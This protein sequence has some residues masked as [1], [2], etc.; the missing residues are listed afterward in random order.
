MK[1]TEEV[2]LQHYIELYENSQLSNHIFRPEK[3][4]KCYSTDCTVYLLQYII[5]S[6]LVR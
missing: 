2:F 6:T 3:A 5:N 4:V 1:S